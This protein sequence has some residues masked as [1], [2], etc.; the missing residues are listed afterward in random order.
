MVPHMTTDEIAIQ[1]AEDFIVAIN[2]PITKTPISLIGDKQMEAIRQLSD[3]Y[4]QHT[5]NQRKLLPR[6]PPKQLAS[7]SRVAAQPS[8]QSNTNH[9][10]N[11]NNA[12]NL[13]TTH[14]YPTRQQQA[15]NQE[16]AHH[17]ITI[18]DD[19]NR[20]ATPPIPTEDHWANAIIDA[21]TGA[22]MEYRHLLKSLKHC[23]AWA[24]SFANELVW[25]AQGIGGRQK[26][27]NTVYYIWHNQFPE[28][29]R[30]YVAYGRI[31]VDYRPQNEE[32]N[33]TRLTVDNNLIEYP[34]DVSTPTA[35]TTTAKMVINSTILRPMPN[36]FVPI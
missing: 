19:T 25:L 6:V 1:A 34:G 18:K 36:S 10:T 29:R 27:T 32:P 3:L 14:R 12:H 23:A 15:S 20:L 4:Q 26:G 8:Q 30:K 35:D 24:T 5:L 11:T 9:N 7:F 2:Q 16:Q 13:P 17:V 28:N 31:Y 33:R 21:G 22:S